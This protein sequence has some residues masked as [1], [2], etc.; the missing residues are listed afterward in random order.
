MV[1]PLSEGQTSGSGFF[2][3][4]TEEQFKKRWINSRHR[5]IKRRIDIGQETLVIEKK[6]KI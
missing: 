3:E 6:G 1:G 4:E 2:I 5:I